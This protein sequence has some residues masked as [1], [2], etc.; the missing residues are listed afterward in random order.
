MWPYNQVGDTK[1]IY[2]LY[3]KSEVRKEDNA[4]YK[5]D[6]Y[7]LQPHLYRVVNELSP[8]PVK[9]IGTSNLS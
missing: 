4:R 5:I 7:E 9:K 8:D 1:T 3:D 2:H 6:V